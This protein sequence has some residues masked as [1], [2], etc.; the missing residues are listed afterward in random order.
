MTFAFC[1][2]NGVIAF[3][4]TVPADATPI[5]QGNYDTLVTVIPQIA[6]HNY[7]MVTVLGIPDDVRAQAAR[8][9]MDRCF[10]AIRTAGPPPISLCP[11]CGQ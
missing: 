2:N 8:N 7:K 3:G 4:E 6:L 1:W 5:A 10:A 9:V 11:E